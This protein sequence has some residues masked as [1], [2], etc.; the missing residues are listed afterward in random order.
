MNDDSEGA[1]T[2]P[3]PNHADLLKTA[4]RLDREE[5][6]IKRRKLAL[7]KQLIEAGRAL[8]G[9]GLIEAAPTKKKRRVQRRRYTKRAAKPT[10]L[11]TPKPTER[12]GGRTPS[13]TGWT[14]TML[15]ILTEANRPMSYAELKAKVMNTP[16][17]PTLARTDKAFYSGV[18][19]LEERKQ[20]IRQNGRISTTEAYERLMRDVAAG[21]AKEEPPIRNTGGD[22]NSPAKAAIFE[23]LRREAQGAPI[24]DIV[25]ELTPKLNLETRNSK[26][27]VYNLIA[28]LVRRGELTKNGKNIRLP[29]EA[30]NLFQHSGAA[31]AVH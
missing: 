29:V 5:A 24:A 28:R 9:D 11:A 27:A 19:K 21:I 15:R 10:P 22:R 25:N 1:M 14:A 2:K 12:K 16:L 3:P 6:A 8:G 30:G 7:A 23:I 13:E 26:T 4:K 18:A 20:A 17:G 31:N